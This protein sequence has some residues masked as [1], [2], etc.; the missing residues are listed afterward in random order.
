MRTRFYVMMAIVL[1]AAALLVDQW[2][3]KLYVRYMI[4]FSGG[5]F[6]WGMMV[7]QRSEQSWMRRRAARSSRKVGHPGQEVAR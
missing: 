1:V 7:G 5:L 6:L 2:L 4:L 3:G